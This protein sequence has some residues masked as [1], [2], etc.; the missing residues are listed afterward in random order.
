MPNSLQPHGLQQFSWRDLSSF[1]FYC[2]PLVI[3]IVDLRMPSYLS[4]FPD[5]SAGKNNLPEMQIWSLVWLLGQED[6][7]QKG[8]ATHS[9]ILAWRSPWM[10]PWGRKESDTTERLSLSLL[11]H[12]S[13]ISRFFSITLFLLPSVI[14]P[15]E[16][17]L[18]DYLF[19]KMPLKFLINSPQPA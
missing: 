4:G 10:S 14:Q 12:S 16:H 17:R 5:S 8:Q 13:F 1:P 7:L 19:L 6:P 11:F 15:H 9:S 2:F 3:C 18:D